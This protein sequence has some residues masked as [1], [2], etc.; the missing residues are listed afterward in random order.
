MER[1]KYVLLYH[2]CKL[3]GVQ[4]VS[5]TEFKGRSLDLCPPPLFPR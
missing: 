2:S 5:R 4:V 3:V 1:T